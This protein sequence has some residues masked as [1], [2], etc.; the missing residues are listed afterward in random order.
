MSRLDEIKARLKRQAADNPDANGTD[1][2]VDADLTMSEGLWLIARVEG[3]AGLVSDALASERCRL[4][5]DRRAQAALRE[6]EEGS[7]ADCESRSAEQ[8][9]DSIDGATGEGR[10]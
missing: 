2:V 7:S 1:D 5:W 10:R 6:L 3:L 4:R 8:E 9:D